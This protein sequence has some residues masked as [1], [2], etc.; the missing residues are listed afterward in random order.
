MLSLESGVGVKG[1]ALPLAAIS[2][3]PLLYNRQFMDCAG[4][5]EDKGDHELGFDIPP[6]LNNPGRVIKVWLISQL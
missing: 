2:S 3:V 6:E 5:Y 1:H 4:R